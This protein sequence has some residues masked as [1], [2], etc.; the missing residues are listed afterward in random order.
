MSL[1]FCY[2]SSGYTQAMKM[3]VRPFFLVMM[4]L[5]FGVGFLTASA[6]PQPAFA[7][8][9]PVNERPD[10][11]RF[12]FSITDEHI[13]YWKRKEK[14]VWILMSPGA[15]SAFYRFTSA[16]VN[17]P[18]DLYINGLFVISI[19]NTSPVKSGGLF[20]GVKKDAQEKVVSYL[21][22]QKQKLD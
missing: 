14:G 9:P 20:I 22:L 13:L 4:S 15:T 6:L 2:A 3:S 10:A 7:S 1:T 8:P 11:L 5:A 18:Y 19:M 21:P 17:Q 12:R 16:H